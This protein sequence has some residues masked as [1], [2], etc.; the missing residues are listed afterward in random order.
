MKAKPPQCGH[1]FDI[2]SWD[3]HC[4]LEPGHAHEHQAKNDLVK[5]TW[6]N[7]QANP[8]RLSQ[9]IQKQEAK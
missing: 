1:S 8:Q 4:Q 6:W 7:E 5:V 9:Q 3:I 2:P